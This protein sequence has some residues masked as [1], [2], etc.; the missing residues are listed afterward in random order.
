MEATWEHLILKQVSGVMMLNLNETSQKNTC[1][2]AMGLKLRLEWFHKQTENFE[3]EEFSDDLG[4][5][6]SVLNALGIPV[7]NNINNGGFNVG[8]QWAAIIQPYFRH[9]IE[10]TDSDYQISFDYRENW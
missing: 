10:I 1:E 5:D 8:S 6:E 4:D 9:T 3:G 2:T 7:E